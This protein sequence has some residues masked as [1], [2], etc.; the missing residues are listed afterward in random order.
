ME[1]F[2]FVAISRIALRISGERDG[3]IVTGDYIAY[4]RVRGKFVP[5]NTDIS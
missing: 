3:A 2:S 4:C 1:H 5:G